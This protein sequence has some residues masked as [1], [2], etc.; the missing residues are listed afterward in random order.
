[1]TVD[2]R[3]ILVDTPDSATSDII[4]NVGSSASP[5]TGGMQFVELPGARWNLTFGYTA[6]TP[7]DG[8]LMKAIKALCRGGA[9]LV[10]VT[11]LSYVPRITELPGGAAPVIAG[12]AQAGVQLATGGWPA[13]TTVF[14]TG[15][16]LSYLSTDGMYRMHTVV[17]D[18]TSSAGG[19]AQVSIL[20]PMRNPPVNGTPVEMIRPCMTA[21]LR[22]GGEVSADGYIHSTTLVFIE[23]LYAIL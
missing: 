9:E 17:G 4:S 19:L 7:A 1:M 6:L 22:E 14:R 8:R 21:T 5:F 13:N 20:P 15:D 23:A 10:H 11:D 2:L 18:S 12:A 3:T 16:Q